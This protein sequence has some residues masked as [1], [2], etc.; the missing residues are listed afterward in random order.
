[1]TN[2]LVFAARLRLDRFSFRT[3]LNKYADIQTYDEPINEN[4]ANINVGNFSHKSSALCDMI[5]VD[6]KNQS[7][8]QK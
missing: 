4:I 6:S 8:L 7:N 1:M 2:G 3:R 5:K